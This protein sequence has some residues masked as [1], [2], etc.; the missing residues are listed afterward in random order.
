[1]LTILRAPTDLSTDFFAYSLRPLLYG[2]L[3]ATDPVR[4]QLPR[5]FLR[6]LRAFRLP[7]VFKK[8]NSNSPSQPPSSRSPSPPFPSLPPP[9]YRSPRSSI[10]C[11]SSY[12][13][14]RISVSAPLHREIGAAVRLSI[15]SSQTH[16]VPVLLFVPPP[17]PTESTA[18]PHD[19][20]K[21]DSESD[22]EKDDGSPVHRE[23]E[24]RERW[25]TVT[26]V[27]M[28]AREPGVESRPGPGEE[29]CISHQ[30]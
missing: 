22:A 26:R 21:N 19:D 8:G 23:R 2:L 14:E 30:I 28:A 18:C 12:H 25:R 6:A 29:E 24:E 11:P 17:P 15:D 7:C 5:I 9:V 10:D 16:A 20:Y 27:S 1:M 13:S 3:V 4:S